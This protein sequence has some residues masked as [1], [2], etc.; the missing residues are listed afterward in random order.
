M[1]QDSYHCSNFY[2]EVPVICVRAVH[3]H[4]CAWKAPRC[5]ALLKSTGIV[6]RGSSSDR[7]LVVLEIIGQ[8]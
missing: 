8:D 7:E 2:L 4:M 3:V 5:V 1:H 6:G